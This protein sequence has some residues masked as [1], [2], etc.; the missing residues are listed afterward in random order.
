[1]AFHP[2]G[3][4]VA[5]LGDVQG[6][7]Y[8]AVET[9]AA[10]LAAFRVAVFASAGPSSWSAVSTRRFRLAG[11]RKFI[12]LLVMW[13]H[14]GA[15]VTAL[16]LGHP[17]P[18]VVSPVGLRELVELDPSPPPGLPQSVSPTPIVLGQ[19]DS[20]VA[21]T[22]GLTEA[23]D[24]EGRFFPAEQVLASLL[25]HPIE[26]QLDGLLGAAASFAGGELSDDVA[27]L[28]IRFSPSIPGSRERPSRPDGR[29]SDRGMQTDPLRADPGNQ[30]HGGPG[31]VGPAARISQAVPC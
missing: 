23:R 19:W 5:V 26:A 17:R 30:A 7:G 16:T 18:C 14:P 6:H 27:L 1:V 3:P 13:L 25:G 2:S 11:R 10:V 22:D 15:T 12:S 21:Y 4:V 24:A 31:R 9:A 20:I 28:A 8:D 29:T